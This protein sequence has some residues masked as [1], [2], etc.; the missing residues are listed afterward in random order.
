M[1]AA[2]DLDAVGVE[3]IEVRREQGHRDQRLVEI[4]ADLLLDARLVARDLSRGHAAHR[5]LA[6]ARAQVLHREAAHVR[7]YV[8]DVG[9]PAHAER[10]FSRGCHG[11]G[12]L[13]DQVLALH[14]GDR[15]LLREVRLES[16]VD[17]E[18]AACG[19]RLARLHVRPKAEVRRRDAVVARREAG[20]RVG[21]VRRCRGLVLGTVGAGRGHGG[22]RQDGA[23]VVSDDAR[24]LPRGLRERW[25]RGEKSRHRSK[26]KAADAR[27]KH[28]PLLRKRLRA[29]LGTLLNGRCC[30]QPV[31]G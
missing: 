19:H 21:A 28:V 3:K 13:P 18:R 14:G 24:D 31:T 9:G 7:R 25:R 10:L 30:R 16:E 27:P 1:G 6:L 12:N 29:E 20:H 15:D 8:L 17:G 4:D 5:H 22:A 2:E 23:G 11:E 26:P